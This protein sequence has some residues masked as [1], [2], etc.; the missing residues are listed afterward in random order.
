LPQA[1]H[2]AAA[3]AIVDASLPG[4]VVLG[5]AAAGKRDAASESAASCAVG[6]LTV[7]Q[8]APAWPCLAATTWHSRLQ[9]HTARHRPQRSSLAPLLPQ[10]WHEVAAGAIVD[11]SLPG[12]VVLGPAAAGKR[13]AASESAASCAVGALTARQLA[14]AWP[15]LAATTWHSRLQNHTAWHRPQRSSLAPLLPQAWHV[16]VAGAIRES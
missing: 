10:T 13:D 2:E 8:L 3:E 14:P 4:S 12:S 16:V 9:N 6:A 1:W 7:R 5:P 15:C 11:T